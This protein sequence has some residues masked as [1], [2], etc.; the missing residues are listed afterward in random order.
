VYAIGDDADP[1]DDTVV[2][3]VVADGEGI[4]VSSAYRGSLPGV[5]SRSRPA[6]RLV[7]LDLDGHLQR[8]RIL[9]PTPVDSGEAPLLALDGHDLIMAGSFRG[10]LSM[11]DR[12]L[13]SAGGEDFFVYRGER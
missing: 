10:Q 13:M 7:E 3:G 9:S 6:P 5:L 4:V 11:R 1:A 12:T 8:T 2:A